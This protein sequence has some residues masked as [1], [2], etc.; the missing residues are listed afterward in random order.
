M[1]SYTEQEKQEHIRNWE[2][3]GLSKAA[4]AKSAGIGKVTFYYWLKCKVKNENQGFIEIPKKVFTSN[5]QSMAIE[6][7]SITVRIPLTV[8]I[9][10][11]QNVITAL[12]GTQ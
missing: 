8:T 6:K 7:G 4:Y 3:G 9:K 12:G 5:E 11:L 1:R 2:K 10:E